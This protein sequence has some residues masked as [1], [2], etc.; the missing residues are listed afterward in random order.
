MAFKAAV[1]VSVFAS[2]D[3]LRK[4]S[5]FSQCGKA[6]QSLF[7]GPNISIVNGEDAAEC[8]WRWQVG[9]KSSTS[10]RPWCGGMLIS[11]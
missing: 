11:P 7:S 9:L 10:G 3:G 1:A 5:S 6:G 2:V 8:A 4:S